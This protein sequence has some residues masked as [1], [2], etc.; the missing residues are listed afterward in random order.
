MASRGSISGD[1]N[2]NY[3]PQLYL[4]WT[5]IYYQILDQYQN[6]GVDSVKLAAKNIEDHIV[7]GR[8][9][10]SKSV[11][12]STVSAYR[13][14]EHTFRNFSRTVLLVPSRKWD[15]PGPRLLVAGSYDREIGWANFDPQR[16][17]SSN[18]YEN[19]RHF[20]AVYIKEEHSN[21]YFILSLQVRATYP[22]L[23]EREYEN[24]TCMYRSV[25]HRQNL[26]MRDIAK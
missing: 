24:D 13:A 16:N 3:D 20:L 23:T 26:R 1:L 19:S 12:S 14:C 9:D 10:L 5:D 25:S 11:I 4:Q 6:G 22:F 18:R 7:S 15:Y 17:N 21:D 8:A 2:L